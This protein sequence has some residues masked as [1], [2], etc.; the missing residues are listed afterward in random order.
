MDLSTFWFTSLGKFYPDLQFSLPY[1]E[2]KPASSYKDILLEGLGPC[3]Y[4]S[5]SG[6]TQNFSVTSVDALSKLGN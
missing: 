3:F 6:H 2:L 5:R 1:I 4:H